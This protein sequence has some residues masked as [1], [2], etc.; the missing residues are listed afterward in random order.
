[1]TKVF[2][3]VFTIP[4]HFATIEDCISAQGIIIDFTNTLGEGGFR[5]VFKALDKEN[6]RVVA[7]KRLELS[8]TLYMKNE[9]KFQNLKNE[10]FILTKAQGNDNIINVF[11]H[12]IIK[13]NDLCKQYCFIIMEYANGGSLLNRCISDGSFK[14]IPER[15]CRQIFKQMADGLFFLHIKL[16]IAHKDI[17]LG[18]FLIVKIKGDHV[19]KISDFGISR[20]GYDSTN[21]EVMKDV[22]AV[23]SY[24]YMSPQVFKLWIYSNHG[25]EVEKRRQYNA[26]IA[27]M[28]ALGVCLFVMV[29]AKYPF[30]CNPFEATDCE[31][32]STK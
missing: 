29:C 16:K 23:G 5:T 17:K 20:I 7:A 15:K 19:I 24:E 26:Y 12:F 9:N 6:G 18:N 30:K 11:K 2:T 14:P 1:M 28:W 8:S 22:E 21:M 13:D 10:L 32:C 4:D 27:D 3:I 25:I 31:G